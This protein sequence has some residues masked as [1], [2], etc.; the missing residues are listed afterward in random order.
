MDVLALDQSKSATGWARYR[1]GEPRPTFGTW[2]LGTANTSRA[3][4]MV[5]L[6]LKLQEAVAFGDPD[7]VYYEMPLPGDRQSNENNNRLANALAAMI[8]FFFACRRVRCHEVSNLA[9]KAT[10]LNTPGRRLSSS[11]W[12]ALSLRV[13]R[14]LGMRPG[15]DNEAD[16]LHILDHG[17]AQEN[18][19]PSWRKDPP[20]IEG[21]GA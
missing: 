2:T 3:A 21:V 11:E 17:L 12:K 18:I 1:E 5:A 10:Q 15:N 6:Y 20:L 4:V 9:W 8:E 14:E 19:I 7:V 13:S 16:A